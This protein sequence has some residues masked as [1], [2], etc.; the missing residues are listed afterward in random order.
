MH[1]ATWTIRPC[2]PREAA[3]LARELGLSET[4]AS[5]LVRRGYTDPDEAVRFLAG[6][7]PGH[8]PFLLGEMGVDTDDPGFVHVE[9]LRIY[10]RD[11]SLT[12]PWPVLADW[13]GLGLVRTRL[14]FDHLLA[15]QSAKAG[16]Q[17]WERTEATG[18][19]VADGWVSGTARRILC[20]TAR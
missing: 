9:G 10:G 3:K 12:L 17:L 15:Q 2:D 13:P 18:P 14:D 20:R 6:K 16:A 19:I 5:V 7:P 8:D 4:T 1:E 11:A